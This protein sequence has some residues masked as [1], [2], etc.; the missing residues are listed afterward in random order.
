MNISLICEKK[1]YNFSLPLEVSLKYIK[2]L[3]SKIFKCKAFDIYYKG[4]KITKEEED[5]EEEI[6]LRDIISCEESNIKLKIIL[7]STAN[8]SKN[9][10]PSTTNSPTYS[11]Q[12][13]KTLDVGANDIIQL[14]KKFYNQKNKLFEAIYSQKVKKLFSSIK[15]F[16]KKIIEIDYFLFK[17]NSKSNDN[18]LMSFEKNLYEFIDGIRLYF[19]KLYTILEINNYV[20]YDEMIHNLN[21]FYKYLNLNDDLEQELNI[22]NNH[23]AQTITSTPIN[24]FPINLKKSEN[25]L[26]L[27]TYN[28][29]NKSTKKPSIKNS[30]LLGNKID[31]NKF[32]L[33]A[34]LLK[35]I[36]NINK[37]EGV[38]INN[39]GNYEFINLFNKNKNY[40][41]KEIKNIIE[42]IDENEKLE[43]NEDNNNENNIEVGEEKNNIYENIKLDKTSEKKNENDSESLK[44][45]QT[46][47]S[48]KSINNISAITKKT[49]KSIESNKNNSSEEDI[50]EIKNSLNKSENSNNSKEQIVPLNLDLIKNIDSKKENEEIKL[51]NKVKQSQPPLNQ[52]KSNLK[53]LNLDSTIQE[54]EN[55]NILSSL[56]NTNNSNKKNNKNNNNKSVSEK[57]INKKE[58]YKNVNNS[59]KNVAKIVK[60]S[61]PKEQKINFSVSPPIYH[62]NS[63]DETE[64]AKVL[65]RRLTMKKKKNK[66]ANKYDF[67]I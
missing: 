51:Q 1:E 4:D 8:N 22:Q 50:K 12:T 19:T 15:E 60:D 62:I 5:D 6:F 56:D 45:T 3:S 48:E 55:E 35:D 16:N 14:A 34:S 20:T 27:D 67:I 39:K 40:V 59:N 9:Q 21:N 58:K 26:N 43:K 52:K 29:F 33:K 47:I 25:T 41:N 7:N 42:N 36:K 61:P 32:Q 17:K 24:K 30:L 66:T 23:E 49:T 37:N 44:K 28:Y 38:D 53:K 64:M 57:K 31:K 18:N 54:N 11:N 13:Y 65:S 2:N 10:T 63:S 46:N